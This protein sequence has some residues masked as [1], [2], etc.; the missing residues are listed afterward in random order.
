MTSLEILLKTLNEN[1]PQY[2]NIL[3]SKD[4]IEWVHVATVSQTH[5]EIINKEAW[6]SQDLFYYK[7]IRPTESEVL[8]KPPT[9]EDTVI[10]L[11][12]DIS[13]IL[14]RIENNGIATYKASY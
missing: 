5:L 4:A 3:F 10:E 9:F 7:V 8:V 14:E 1:P 11:L 12:T 2:G 13:K 6:N